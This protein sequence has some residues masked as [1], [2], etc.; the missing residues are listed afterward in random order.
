MTQ[1]YC[2]WIS[3]E[4]QEKVGVFHFLYLERLVCTKG[5]RMQ[6]QSLASIRRSATAIHKI[7]SIMSMILCKWCL[8]FHIKV[9]DETLTKHR[10]KSHTTELKAETDEQ[11]QVMKQGYFLQLPIS[12]VSHLLQQP[13]FFIEI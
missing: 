12:G 5:K 11:V 3:V 9:Q 13:A 6:A 1:A 2:L 10:S 4:L 7:I 8:C